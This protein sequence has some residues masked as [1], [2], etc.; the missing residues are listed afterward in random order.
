[1]FDGTVYKGKYI[2]LATGSTSK[3]MGLEIGGRVLTSTEALNMEDLPKSAIVLGGGVIGVE[4]ASVWKSFGVDVT[5]VEGLPSAVPKR[6]SSH[7]QEPGACF[8]EARHQVQHRCLL[9]KG[10]AGCQRRQ[11]SR[12]ADGKVLEA[13]NRVGCSRPRSGQPRVLLRGAGHHHRCRGFVITN[14]VCTP[15][16]AT[17]Y[18]IGDIV[19]GVQLAHRGYQHG[20]FVAEEIHG[21]KPTIVEDI[22]I[23]KVTFCEP[24]IASVGYSEPKAK[25]KF[26]ADQ[27]ETTECTW[28]VTASPQSWAPAASSRWFASRTAQSLAFTASA[29]A[30]VSRSVKHRLIV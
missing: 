29:A 20:R 18:A 17:F 9:R 14:G 24:E 23:P 19:P 6:K 26:G 16:L 8:Q 25:E 12:S 21:L 7:H 1:M 22:N 3:T 15:A 5:I 13:E 11:V 30:L 10:R 4:F 2:I 27:I 28:L